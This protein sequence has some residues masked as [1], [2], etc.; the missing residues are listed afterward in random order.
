M[1][2]DFP[3]NHRRL[4]YRFDIHNMEGS[5]SILLTNTNLNQQ[6]KHDLTKDQPYGLLC[7]RTLR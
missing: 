6:Q 5:L 1:I 7:E 2:K 4:S 3:K